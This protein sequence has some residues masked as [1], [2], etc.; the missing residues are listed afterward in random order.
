MLIDETRKLNPWPFIGI[1]V[2]LLAA[3]YGISTRYPGPLPSAPL[4]V[5]AFLAFAGAVIACVPF[6]L[7]HTRKQEA[8]LEE[9]RENSG[10]QFDPRIVTVLLETVFAP[11][12][13]RADSAG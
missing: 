3:A 4:F 12:E 1:D 5:C 13:R 9:I 11:D 7:N 10:T 2:L 8:A 6:L